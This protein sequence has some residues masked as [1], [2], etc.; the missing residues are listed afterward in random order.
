MIEIFT[1]DTDDL[2]YLKIVE[3]ILVGCAQEYE[4]AGIYITR[5]KGWFDH[6]WLG[7]SG[8][9]Y[10]QLAVWKKP[11][12]LPPFNPTRVLSQRYFHWRPDDEEYARATGWARLA[13]E[14]PS[15]ENLKRY[16]GRVGRSVVLVWF[17]SDTLTT[18]RGSLMVYVRTPRKRTAWFVSLDKKDD[19]WRKTAENISLVEVEA[20]EEAGRQLEPE[21]S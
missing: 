15:S 11:L 20:F 3:R 16:V 4:P 5:I 7:F 14:Q 13:R 1:D 18:G 21:V 6:K 10:G 12:T 17:C 19:I 2:G 8:K 9:V